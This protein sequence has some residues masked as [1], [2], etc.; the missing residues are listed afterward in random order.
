MKEPVSE[1]L[2]ACGQLLE[3]LSDNSNRD[4]WTGALQT[5][6]DI[7]HLDLTHLDTKILRATLKDMEAG[8]R[9]FAQHQHTRKVTLFGS[10]RSPADSAE[11]RQAR[12]FAKFIAQQGFAVMTGGGS[13]IMEAG[14]QGAGLENSF[15]LNIQLPFEQESNPVI[16]SSNREI[17][18]KY[19]FIRKL[20]FLKESD[21]VVL[22]P[23]GFGTQ[24]EGFETLTLMQTGKAQ[25]MPLVLVDRPGGRY[26]HEWDDYIRSHLLARGLVSPEDVEIYRITDDVTVACNEIASF[27]RT[28]HSNR[29]VGDRLI[30]RLNA[31]LTDESVEI[32]NDKFSDILLSGK[33]KK[34]RALPAEGKKDVEHLP[35]L[36]MHF[37]QR[38]FGRLW[39][40]VRTL[41]TLDC[42]DRQTNPH[43]E[44]K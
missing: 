43:P 6:V 31:E 1:T 36:A 37:N 10:A 26:W 40:L 24:D 30:I 16:A 15:G 39:Q 42:I 41:N 27:Y 35:R 34:T 17:Q 19:F 23:G 32:L 7:G 4:V 18:F 28:F 29:F 20:F 9:A 44:R 14:N 8:Y 33:I 12:D 38:N 25:L 5:L 3:Q 21:A 11:Y 13:G 22:F 2:T